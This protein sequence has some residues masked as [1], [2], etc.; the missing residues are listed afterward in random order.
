MSLRSVCDFGHQSLSV[1]WGMCYV[2]TPGP[3]PQGSGCVD[4][5][6]GA[7]VCRFSRHSLLVSRWVSSLGKEKWGWLLGLPDLPQASSA[8]RGV[9]GFSLLLPPTLVPQITPSWDVFQVNSDS[10]L[11][12]A[13]S[14]MLPIL[15]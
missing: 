15:G 1:P 13:L 6:L 3:H 12:V 5:G 11:N 2:Q 10:C 8:A 14:P 7:G 4:L 9:G